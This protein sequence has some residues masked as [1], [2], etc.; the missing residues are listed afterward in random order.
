MI[1]AEAYADWR[2]NIRPHVV[3]QYM[4]TD[5]AAFAESWNNYTDALCKDGHLT[6]LQYHHCPAF[7]DKMPVDQDAERDFIL[8]ALGLRLDWIEVGRRPE[9]YNWQPGSRHFRVQIVRGNIPRM[10][11]FYSQGPAVKGVPTLEGVLYS[12]LMDSAGADE[13]VTFEDWA[14]DMGMDP[15]SR[16]AER[17]FKACQKIAADMSAI[18]TITE[19][20]G[21]RDLF[22][23]Y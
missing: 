17:T 3:A 2:R 14:A 15:D 20:E 8:D 4:P 5:R 12:L 11:T 6:A 22:L 23:D 1:Y 16:G 19:L 10:T 13:G 9:E 21:L 7:D 18:F